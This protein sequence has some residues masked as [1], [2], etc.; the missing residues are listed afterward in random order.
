MTTPARKPV[1]W[2]EVLTRRPA[3]K[4]R[5]FCFPFAGGGSAAYRG[6]SAALPESVELVACQLPGRENRIAEEFVTDI[7]RV[8][9]ILQDEIAPYL[10]RPFVFFGHSMGG[11]ICFEL[12]RRLL[13]D[14]TAHNLR[15]VLV[16]ACRP[17]HRRD[18]REYIGRLPEKEF[19]ARLKDLDGT[20]DEFFQ[21]PELMEVFIPILRADFCLAESYVHYEA[22]AL[23]VALEALAGIDDSISLDHMAEWRRYT[24][25]D[26]RLTAFNGGHFFIN[27]QRALVLDALQA[28]LNRP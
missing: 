27:S 11:S 12:A 10:D 13:R 5:M 2:F 25:A 19:I 6:W 7:A 1:P 9:D 14:G 16:S 3:A 26:F 23:P 4:Y 21:M 20:P 24:R 8:V 17:P 15:K 22:P 18:E 28:A